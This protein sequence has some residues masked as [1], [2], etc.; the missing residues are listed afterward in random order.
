MTTEEAISYIKNRDK[1][2]AHMLSEKENDARWEKYC[3]A[4][5]VLSA[6]GIT[7]LREMQ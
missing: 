1:T 2:P 4:W 5:E 6:A 7:S 3:A